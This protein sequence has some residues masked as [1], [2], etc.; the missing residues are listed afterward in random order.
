LTV[1]SSGF[2]GGVRPDCFATGGVGEDGGT[3]SV[4]TDSHMEAS[5][6]LG[7]TP[8]GFKDGDGTCG[9]IAFADDDEASTAGDEGGVAKRGFRTVTNPSGEAVRPS[10]TGAGAAVAGTMEEG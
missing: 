2:T 6:D 10:V 7:A 1:T 5:V 4:L 8:A 9:G 3:M